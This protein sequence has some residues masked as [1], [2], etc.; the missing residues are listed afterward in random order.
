LQDRSGVPSAIVSLE[1]RLFDYRISLLPEIESHYPGDK[2]EESMLTESLKNGAAFVTLIDPLPDPELLA[3]A[4]KRLAA[5]LR[6]DLPT[7]KPV[8][9]WIAS[10]P[11]KS[12][13]SELADWFTASWK[14]ETKSLEEMAG[15]AG[16]DAD[17][18]H[19]CGRQLARPFFHALGKLIGAL[20]ILHEGRSLA[21]GCPCCGG[22]PRMGRF[23]HEEGRRFL[24]CDLCNLEWVFP[25]ITCAFCLNQDHKKLGYLTIEGTENYR[26]DVC[27]ICHGYL[28]ALDERGLPEGPRADFLVEDVGTFHLCMVAER[29]GYTPG[30]IQGRAVTP[31][32]TALGP[33]EGGDAKA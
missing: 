32:G 2:P 27:E 16:A 7:F 19:W 20:P 30:S 29:D 1:Q 12:A 25:R 23:E 5:V 28:R 13:E 31:T 3:N 11:E 15:K 22:A 33:P 26:I 14:S 8:D 24:W 4:A 17:L 21:A 9:Q 18:L 6:K 10:M